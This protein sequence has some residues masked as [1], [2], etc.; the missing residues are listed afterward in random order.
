MPQ[1]F[2]LPRLGYPR[3]LLLQYYTG[4]ASHRASSDLKVEVLDTM[5]Q[6]ED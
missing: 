4:N 2:L 1:D 3:M 6:W 5:C